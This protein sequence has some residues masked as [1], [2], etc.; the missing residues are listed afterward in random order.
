MMSHLPGLVMRGKAKWDDPLTPGFG[1]AGKKGKMQGG[2]EPYKIMAAV[3]LFVVSMTVLGRMRSSTNE[4]GI[5]R[6]NVDS[7][8]Q[9]HAASVGVQPVGTVQQAPP[10]VPLVGVSTGHQAVKNR[11]MN[12]GAVA[13]TKSDAGY[14]SETR[15]VEGDLVEIVVRTCPSSQPLVQLFPNYFPRPMFESLRNDL[16]ASADM[17]DSSLLQENFGYTTGWMIRFNAEGID[18]VKADPKF[19]IVMPYFEKARNPD[20]NAFVINYLVCHQPPEGEDAV[21]YHLDNSVAIMN[22]I[23]VNYTHVAHQVNVL[24]LDVPEGLE[25]GNLEVWPFDKGDTEQEKAVIGPTENLMAEFRGDAFHRVGRMQ[26]PDGLPRVG[27]VFEQYKITPRFY[28]YL[29]PFCAGDDCDKL[30][31][32]LP[33]TQPTNPAG[34][35]T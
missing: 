31:A 11:M 19:S 16:H 15:I 1:K 32:G 6:E 17:T 25:G 13:D 23:A 3:F 34:Q 26:L 28:K 12:P 10:V 9:Q 35:S 8:P 29:I 5:V 20:A 14:Y 2:N 22:E 21:K 24:Y 33:L 18:R 4:K 7:M 30:S 27:I